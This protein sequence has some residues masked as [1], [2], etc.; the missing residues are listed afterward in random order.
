MRNVWLLLL[1]LAAGGGL[2]FLLGGQETPTGD[3]DWEVSDDGEIVPRPTADDGMR[4]AGAQRTIAVLG[5]P[6]G[7]NVAPFVHGEAMETQLRF[8]EGATKITGADW[9]AAVEKQAGKVMPLLFPSRRELES[10]RKATLL[11]EAP[12]PV[13]HVQESLDW[14]HARGFEAKETDGRLMIHRRREP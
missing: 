1:V 9:L 10:F 7:A 11:D 5:E 14:L 12:P 13:V 3:G 2:W 4:S 8:A 6:M